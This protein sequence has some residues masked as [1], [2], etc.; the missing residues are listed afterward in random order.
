MRLFLEGEVDGEEGV[1]WGMQGDVVDQT[2]ALEEGALAVNAVGIILAALAYIDDATFCCVPKLWFDA[3]E[4]P[5]KVFYYH[6][7]GGVFCSI[8]ICYAL[9]LF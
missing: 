9:R 2:A 6:R 1:V 3:A 5:F 4:L 8:S 7:P